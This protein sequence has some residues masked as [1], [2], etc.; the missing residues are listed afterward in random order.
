MSIL[1]QNKQL[2][3]CLKHS[4]L[5]R[6]KVNGSFCINRVDY[7]GSRS[8]NRLGL[9]QKRLQDLPVWAAGFTIGRLTSSLETGS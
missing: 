4:R 9:R 1:F 3:K 7:A 5:E 6:A 8:S 2:L